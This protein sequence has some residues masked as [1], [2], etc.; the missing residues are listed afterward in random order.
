MND[1]I[2]YSEII[3]NAAS[4]YT[5]LPLK[6][7]Y[8][9]YKKEYYPIFFNYIDWLEENCSEGYMCFSEIT[10]YDGCPLII[11]NFNLGIH[12]SDITDATAFKLS[13]F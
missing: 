10:E 5:N 8:M 6:R 4:G 3:G 2:I 12:F 13:C 9:L 1:V 7:D 11:C